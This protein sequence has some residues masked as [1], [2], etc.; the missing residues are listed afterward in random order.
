MIGFLAVWF[1]FSGLAA[2]GSD[3]RLHILLAA[4]FVHLA[5]RAFWLTLMYRKKI[6]ILP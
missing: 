2:P 4:Y 3:A 5:F 6:V 1:A